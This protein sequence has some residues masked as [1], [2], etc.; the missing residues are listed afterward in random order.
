M[1]QDL[2]KRIIE[3]LS[4]QKMLQKQLAN[5]LSV[6]ES[7]VSRYL[8][9]HRN[10]K[11]TTLASIAIALNTT[12]DYL[13]GIEKENLDFTYIEKMIEKNAPKM[14]PEEK[15]KLIKILGGIL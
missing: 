12:S 5:K 6:S 11:A 2:S 7:S 3:E 1:S 13:L 8:T 4:K 9:N 15:K 14:T 10:M